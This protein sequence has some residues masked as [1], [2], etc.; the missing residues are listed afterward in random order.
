MPADSYEIHQVERE[1]LNE[2]WIWLRNEELKNNI[3]NRRLTL[4]VTD[5][6][7]G[8]NVCCEV[9]YADD[10]Y[11]DNRRHPIPQTNQHRMLFLSAWYRH[12]LGVEGKVGT[13]RRFDIKLTSNPLRAMWWQ[14]RACVRHPQIAV[15]MS[16][17]LA[18]VG[19]GLGIVGVAFVFKDVNWAAYIWQAAA[20]LG[21]VITLFGLVPLLLRVKN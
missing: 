14:I 11:L 2:G 15:V 7:S 3:E 4:R 19:T 1:D 18:I 21:F 5:E 13:S 9:L 20:G 12:R 16:T 10:T 8:K 17:V 6:L